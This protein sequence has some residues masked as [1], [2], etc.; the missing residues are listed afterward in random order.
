MSQRNDA[1]Y[2]QS[3]HP[4]LIRHAQ[5]KLFR[6]LRD[7]SYRVYFKGYSDK[8]QK[9]LY[10]HEKATGA[11]TIRATFSPISDSICNQIDQAVVSAIQDREQTVAQITRI[12]SLAARTIRRRSERRLISLEQQ[13]K[14][15]LEERIQAKL[16]ALDKEFTL[17][18]SQFEKDLFSLS[19]SA[20]T[21]LIGDSSSLTAATIASRLTPILALL[22]QSEIREIEVSPGLSSAVQQSVGAS[23]VRLC[24]EESE[25]ITP[26]DFTLTTSSGKIISCLKD[27]VSQTVTALSNSHIPAITS[28]QQRSINE[29]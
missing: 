14:I 3:P 12:R 8:I 17:R 6:F 29:C 23:K 1:V 20:I 10:E 16:A 22:S 15:T 28:H 18:V 27:A 24:I 19:I 9:R 4:T 2:G 5:R 25:Q 7:N 21:K 26:G 13:A 11:M